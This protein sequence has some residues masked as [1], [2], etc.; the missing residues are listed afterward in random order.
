MTGTIGPMARTVSDVAFLDEMITGQKVQALDLR[1]VRI[2]IP[3]EDYWSI[4]AMEP[5]VAIITQQAFEKLRAAGA[6]L[7]EIDYQAL[8]DLNE[9]D[10]LGMA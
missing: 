7:V 5:E 1:K 8:I 6:Q 3:Q 2:G 10:R 9:G 4:Q